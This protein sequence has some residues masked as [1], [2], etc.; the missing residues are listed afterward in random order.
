LRED[1]AAQS[2]IKAPETIMILY[3]QWRQY[4][5]CKVFFNFG[6]THYG[7]RDIR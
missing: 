4:I 5:L 7:K 6:F 2:S 1:N 3:N